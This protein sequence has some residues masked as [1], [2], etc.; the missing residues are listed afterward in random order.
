[1]TAVVLG[2]GKGR[3]RDPTLARAVVHVLK[4]KRQDLRA[5]S[6]SCTGWECP[7]R[8]LITGYHPRSALHV[9]AAWRAVCTNSTLQCAI[10]V[11]PTANMQAATVLVASDG[12]RQQ[13]TSRCHVAGQHFPSPFGL[14]GGD[15]PW[16]EFRRPLLLE[17]VEEPVPPRG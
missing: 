10:S 5:A 7:T 1:M 8:S 17:A 2:S 4:E 14:G 16:P 15:S 11:S 6:H 3:R 12:R 13:L 9:A